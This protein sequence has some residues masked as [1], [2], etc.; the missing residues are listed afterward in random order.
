MKTI[1]TLCLA[2]ML[3]SVNG[4]AQNRTEWLDPEVNQVNRMPM[5]TYYFAYESEELAMKGDKWLSEN[6]MSL[7]GIW[8]FNWVKD[9][10]MRPLDFYKTDFNDRGWGQNACARKLGNERIWRPAVCQSWLSM[11]KPD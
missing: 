10:D 6:I 11:E 7:N 5:H 8:K 2:M 1:K 4:V 9:S 3:A